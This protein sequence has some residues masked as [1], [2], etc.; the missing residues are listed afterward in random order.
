MS[1]RRKLPRFTMSSPYPSAAGLRLLLLSSL[2]WVA[3]ASTFAARAAG[4]GLTA[5]YFDNMDC[6]SLKLS[7]VDSTVNFDWG[8][9]SPHA[10]VGADTF[11]VR[12]QGQLEPRFAEPTTF[13]VTA[14]DGAR[15]WVDD[16]LI[17][18][19]VFGAPDAPELRGQ[20][21]LP[22]GRRVNLRIEFIENTGNA[23]VRLEWSS[24]NQPRE[25]IPQSQLYP[26]LVDAESGTLLAETWTGLPGTDLATLTNA[27]AYPVRPDSREYLSGFE[28]LLT[29][30][31]DAH[32]TRVSGWLVAPVDGDYTFAVAAD[33]RAA[34]YLSGNESQAGKTLIAA[35]TNAT[36]FRQ[37]THHAG[38]IS[39][40]VTL[41]AGQKYFVELLHKEGAGG[42]HFSVAWMPP[43]SATFEVI[44]ADALV[45]A[46]LVTPAPPKANFLDGV[47][48]SRSRL[49]ASAA[50]FEWLKRE[51]A[52]NPS[53]Q[54]AQWFN[55]L[56][57]AAA[58]ILSQPV[59]TY[60]LDERS[61]LLNTSRS[62]VDRLYKLALVWRITG[63]TNFAERAWAELEAAAN[64][65]N[66]NP[67]H[68]LDTAEMTHAFAIGYDWL[69]D[70][71]TPARLTTLRSAI[72]NKGLTPGLAEYTSNKSWTRADANNWNLVCNGGLAMGALAL[73]TD[74]ETMAEDILFRAVASATPVMKRFTTENGGWYEGPG[75]WG[76]TTEYANLLLAGLESALGS[77]FS[78]SK[79]RG[80]SESG[81]FAIQTVGPQ[82]RS[83]NFADAGAGN[84][85]GPQMFWYAKR[86]NRPL[87]AWHQRT[88]GQPHVLDALW[89]DARG[90][91]PAAEGLPR[92]ACFRGATATTSFKTA[93]IVTLRSGWGDSQATFLGY[94]GGEMGAA[95]GQLDAGSF[96]LD[97]MGYRWVHDL[98]ADSYALPGYFSTPRWTYYRNRAEGHNTLVINP[99]ADGGMRL[100]QVAPVLMF[101][102]EP[103]Q[104]DSRSIVDL[105]PVYTNV[106]RVWRG[107]HLFNNRRD[108]LIQ[109]EIRTPAP[110][111]VWSFL[112]IQT[113]AMPQISPDGTSAMLTQG[114]ARLWVKLITSNAVF[115][116]RNAE[117]LPSSP[118]PAGQNPNDNFR[119]LSLQFTGL[120]NA[121][122]AVWLRPLWP[123]ESPPTELPPLTPLAEWSHGTNVF[124]IPTN[125]PPTAQPRQQAAFAGSTLDFDLRSLAGDFETTS[126]QLAF[127][128]GLATNGTAT[129]LS[130]GRTAR[131][132]VTAA[133]PASASFRYTVADVWPEPTL[134]AAYDFE[135]PE[136]LADARITERSGRGFDGYLTRVGTGAHD[137]L[138]D[139]PAAL[140]PYSTQSL[141]MQENGDFNGATLTAPITSTDLN[142]RTQDWTASLWFKRAA[143]GNDDFLFYLGNSDGFGSPDELH[144]YCPANQDSLALRHYVAQNT[145]DVDLSAPNVP[146]NQWRHAAV[147]FQATN[148]TSGIMSLYLNGARVG[149]NVNVTLNLPANMQVI[150]GGHASA[151]FAVTRWLNGSLDD[152]AVFKRALSPAEIARLATRPVG[153]FGGL[154]ATNVVTV[155]VQPINLPPVPADPGSHTLVSGAWLQ[156]TNT[157][158]DPN[159]PA[160][161]LSWSLPQAPPG[162][163]LDPLT[164]LLAWRPTL[165]Q[166]GTSHPFTVVVTEAGWSTN[167]L[168]EADAY[169]RDG[170]SAGGNFGSDPALVVKAGAT[171]LARETFLR[172]PAP[173]LPG[174]PGAATLTLHPTYANVPG[175]QAVALVA[176]DAW[177]EPTLTWNNK[178]AAGPPLASW[179]PQAG[180]S[181]ALNLT[182]P[183]AAEQAG[184]GRMSLRV[185][186]TTTTS[187]GR[188]DYAARESGTPLA[189]QL[190]LVH[191]N[192]T[193]L[194]A[195]QTFLVTVVAPR[196]PTLAAAGVAD[197][198]FRM[199]VAGDAGPDY[200]V[201]T[202]TNLTHWSALFTSNSP[203][204]PFQFVDPAPS[205]AP[206]RFYRVTPGP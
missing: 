134:A 188:V 5:E 96:V 132:T 1:R 26:T 131:F 10:S 33:D 202:S 162:A 171:G 130:D 89:H 53:G 104:G 19:R 6:T 199:T 108:V 75:Y 128:V 94:H 13:H 167:L 146:L 27:P 155:A 29:D 30:W 158:S 157:A 137:L 81:S 85:R 52:A 7:R 117:P 17:A 83:F 39:A 185:F 112:H 151:G 72:L 143:R 47:A 12:W 20:I 86:F 178:P 55:S 103:A 194:S 125:T 110:A 48:Q 105:T 183:L 59:N 98:G 42:D 141:R 165:A 161:E 186:A 25:V 193:T 60:I 4:T 91:D 149:S 156:V 189:P 8:G 129:L 87:F 172:F 62:V 140:A 35:V 82:L 133:A 9:G 114:A 204:M 2:T 182:G 102:S 31:L 3:L 76:Y 116:L 115:T 32:G 23:S 22:A 148:A 163:T 66:W 40:P 90:G 92:D 28:C 168:P 69:H 77:S 180:T 70:Y 97:A 38:Q 136:D 45:P 179:L 166:A 164:G 109:D 120:T 106:T 93:E 113:N 80:F 46:G 78:L 61:V 119:K 191:T 64:F 175:Q 139:A 181:V 153:Y 200:T 11:S 197:G 15:L 195:T 51:R 56:S 127:T 100:G 14:D 41:A 37:W 123:G 49:L 111:T 63:N 21:A 43:G 118:N 121:T 145:T 122:I 187:D 201:W 174:L 73:G 160:Q 205:I 101:L 88:Y 79:T 71:W 68:F 99:T 65:P 57:N 126:N 24:A 198:L 142:F 173:L 144:L 18:A 190:R 58:A 206:G 159:T 152:V 147:V 44:G 74:E 50:R 184:D 176:D 138:A 54:P 177:S 135:A 170:S 16:K 107:Y 150:F 154:T 84:L 196:P 34:L 203:P 36:G 124:V 67:P 192:L 95:H 169:V